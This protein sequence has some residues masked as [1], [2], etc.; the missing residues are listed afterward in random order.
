MYTVAQT[1][2]P[3]KHTLYL[4]T[5]LS[6]KDTASDI[7]LFISHVVIET[8]LCLIHQNS[9]K[10]YFDWTDE[11]VLD[12]SK[13]VSLSVTALCSLSESSQCFTLWD[14]DTQSLQTRK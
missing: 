11:A 8:G 3:Y 4:G 9:V 12:C 13:R 10:K 7:V 1:M 14:F 5:G 2:P 6:V